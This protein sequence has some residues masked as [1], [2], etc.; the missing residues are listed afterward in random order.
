MGSEHAFKFREKELLCVLD[1]KYTYVFI[2]ICTV[3]SFG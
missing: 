3:G 1:M 2:N